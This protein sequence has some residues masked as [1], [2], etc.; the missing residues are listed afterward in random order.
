MNTNSVHFLCSTLDRF[1][2]AGIALWTFGGWAEELWQ[3]IPARTHNDID[4][5][6]PAASFELLDNIIATES[7]L[8][9]KIPEKHFSHKRAIL[10]GGVMLEFLLVQTSAPTFV[11]SF[12]DGHYRLQWPADTFDHSLAV[13]QK[14]VAVASR[15]ALMHYRRNHM[16]IEQ[17]Y[18]LW[19]QTHDDPSCEGAPDSW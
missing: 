19:L 16:A 15:A 17:A 8:F 9:S 12:F 11:T 6:Y 5:L 10:S 4:F 18:A 7:F 1:Q 14:R 13:G 2:H 3:R